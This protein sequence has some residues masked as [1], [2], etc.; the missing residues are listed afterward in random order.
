MAT[1][2]VVVLGAGVSGL[3]TALAL[4][5]AGHRVTLVERDE[6]TAGEALD[7]IGWR[8]QGIPH[9][10]QA[11]AFTAR[12]RRE[13]RA[14]FPD[15]Y[16]AL[17]DA[18]AHEIDLRPKLRGPLRTEDEELQI[19]GVRRAVIEWALRRAVL[20]EPG[21]TVRSGVQVVGLEATRGDVPVVTGALAADG[22]IAADLV[23]DAMGR[24]SPVP[25]WITALG[26]RRMTE[27]SSD[28]GVIYYTRYYRVRAGASLPDGPWVPT[29][30]A[31]LGYGLFS[32]F[33]GDN[34][35]F[36]GLIAIPPGDQE[37]K[38]LRRAPAFDA[39]TATMPA[40]HSWTNADTSEPITDVLPMGS[41]Q[42]TLRSFVDGRP[43]AIGLI[44]IGDAL[45]HTDPVFALGL[46]FGLVEARELAAA[47]EAHGRDL[48]AVALAFDAAVRPP[49]V[50]RFANA[51]AVD[52]LRLRAWQGEPLD[53]AH[54][55]GGAYP[56]FAFA[57]GNAAALVD[58]DVFRTMIRRNYFLDPLSVLDDDIAMQERIER[59]FV[60]L[61][62]T[63]RPRP[64]P[65]R[66]ELIE[67]M[68]TAL[69]A[70]DG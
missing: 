32:T 44:S 61:R 28:C 4:G 66:D 27:S 34:D 30:R 38:V 70:I 58:G 9:F 19:L 42:N 64:G 37:L 12:G 53:V 36:A 43:S 68:R 1:L 26:G 8:R 10:H 11:H 67:V 21:I 17:L 54:R 39:A 15:V 33:P 65:S 20:R 46:S 59:I 35:T 45:F 55:D 50:E 49:M 69:A 62:S 3:A 5:R 63:P 56:L 48:E 7:A 40:L 47:I 14:A 57:A 16:E 22:P 52:G 41:L 60:D 25:D 24:R 31:D 18:G 6:V 29:P 23:V 2:S 13:L 51:T